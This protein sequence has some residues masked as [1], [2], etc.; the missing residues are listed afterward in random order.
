MI[1]ILKRK[2][3][4]KYNLRSKTHVKVFS[5]IRENIKNYMYF[6]IQKV[7]DDNTTSLELKA[8]SDLTFYDF[9]KD[10][11]LI[12]ESLNGNYKIPDNCIY[13]PKLDNKE[14]N[15]NYSYSLLE[16][17]FEYEN[18]GINELTKNVMQ[19]GE[20]D[21]NYNTFL[22]QYMSINTYIK[23]SEYIGKNFILNDFHNNDSQDFSNSK[24]LLN[25]NGILLIET[26][27]EYEVISHETVT[28]AGY[29]IPE[30]DRLKQNTIEGYKKG[31][32]INIINAAESFRDEYSSSNYEKTLR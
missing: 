3:D 28:M 30:P 18:I 7:M 27:G 6:A 4:A 8:L 29:D 26:N 31:I 2:V 20:L 19:D 5:D 15:R 12:N 25:Y 16:L 9:I 24:L 13:I 23:K 17:S 10:L 22:Y 11:R 1:N 14:F 32:L 21:M